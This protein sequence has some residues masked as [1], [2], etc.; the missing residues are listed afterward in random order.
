M[1][2]TGERGRRDGKRTE[3]RAN[4]LERME[5]AAWISRGISEERRSRG[6][7]KEEENIGLE[8]D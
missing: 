1:R 7:R 6:E 8:T 4:D 3:E 2:I 5:E